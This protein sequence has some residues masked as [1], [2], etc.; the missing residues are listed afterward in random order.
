MWFLYG[1]VW[2][3][4]FTIKYEELEFNFDDFIYSF[5]HKIAFY[6]RIY[7][8]HIN[9]SYGYWTRSTHS[10]DKGM[11]T[12]WRQSIQRKR[13]IK[14]SKWSEEISNTILRWSLKFFKPKKLCWVTKFI[15]D[16]FLISK[17]ITYP[18]TNN[19]K[20]DLPFILR[21]IKDHL[22]NLFFF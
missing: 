3:G 17:H 15:A 18:C 20:K 7:C 22:K 16:I 21:E 13:T 10:I 2:F 6:C 14:F 4:N 9:M 8:M 11:L 5:K 19:K 1:V 12:S